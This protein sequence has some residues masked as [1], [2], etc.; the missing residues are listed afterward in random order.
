MRSYEAGFR[1]QVGQIV[2]LHIAATVYHSRWS[3][4]QADLLNLEGF[5]LTRNIGNGNVTGIDASADVEFPDGW[6]FQA[7]GT[8]NDTKLDRVLPEGQ[9]RRVQFPNVPDF[10]SYG[11]IFKR[12]SSRKGDEFGLSISGRYIGQS[13]LDIDQQNRI[14][15]GRFG[16]IEAAAWWTGKHWGVRAEV[17]N[18]TNAKGNR[19][20]FGN[21][22]TVRFEDQATPLRPLTLQI[23]ISL[24]R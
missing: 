23:E 7:A 14:E 1:G 11:Q 15:Q 9:V 2:P 12:W 8:W 5:P 3:D 19:F 21:P 17:L 20:A 16:S 18:L 24:R 4:V 13:F 10:S 6:R 22:F